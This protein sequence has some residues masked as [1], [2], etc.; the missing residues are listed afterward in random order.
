[1]K[2]SEGIRDVKNSAPDVVMILAYV[3]I[4]AVL[5][6]VLGGL[7]ITGLPAGIQTFLNT[8]LGTTAITVFTALTGVL[9]TIISLLIVAVLWKMFGL[10]GGKKGDSM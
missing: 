3:G 7:D 6:G 9:V 4:G 5:I 1:M 10:G 8:T 2:I